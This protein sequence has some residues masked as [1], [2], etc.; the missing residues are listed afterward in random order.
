MSLEWTVRIIWWFIIAIILAMQLGN[1]LYQKAIKE[2]DE[3]ER[4]F[5]KELQEVT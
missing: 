1:H 2:L 4:Q 3:H 5:L